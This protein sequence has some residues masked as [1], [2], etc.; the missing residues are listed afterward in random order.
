MLGLQR[1]AVILPAFGFA[2]CPWLGTQLLGRA[3][4]KATL[5]QQ[6]AV[7]RCHAFV[8]NASGRGCRGRRS[9]KRDAFP[10]EN[11][12]GVH[13]RGPKE[14]ERKVSQPHGARAGR[15]IKSI[16]G[17][18]SQLHPPNEINGRGETATVE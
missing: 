12:V 17:V 16:W 15:T 6:A 14:R 13:V 18:F 8:S 7:S 5:Y 3:V 4:R 9:E 1:P 11:V 10:S 2:G